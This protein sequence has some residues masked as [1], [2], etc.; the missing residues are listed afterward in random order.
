LQKRQEEIPYEE[1]T[2]ISMRKKKAS[3]KKKR[4]EGRKE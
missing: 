1:I 3:D 4:K 2:F